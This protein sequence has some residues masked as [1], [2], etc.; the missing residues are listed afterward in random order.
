[1][2]GHRHGTQ[3]RLLQPSNE[4]V[5]GV[6]SH[7][8]FLMMTH[9]GSHQGL[10]SLSSP[11]APPLC[12]GGHRGWSHA[13]SPS[14]QQGRPLLW[15]QRKDGREGEQRLLAVK[16]ESVTIGGFSEILRDLAPILASCPRRRCHTPSPPRSPSQLSLIGPGCRGRRHF[17]RRRPHL[18]RCGAG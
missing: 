12:L 7:Q 14:R 8:C 13:A 10:T 16:G 9:R 3:T 2:P 18:H 1:M 11:L 15:G 17:V 6:E 5:R 4:S